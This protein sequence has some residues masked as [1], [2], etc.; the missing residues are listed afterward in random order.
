MKKASVLLAL[1]IFCVGG[2]LAFRPK[3]YYQPAY[4]GGKCVVPTVIYYSVTPD[5][6]MNYLLGR[7]AKLAETPGD[8]RSFVIIGE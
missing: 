1:I 2:V 8:C 4:E 5:T 7:R 3:E 6:G